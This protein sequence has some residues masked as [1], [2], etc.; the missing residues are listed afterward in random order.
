MS[1]TKCETVD[2]T[3]VPIDNN[4]S[5]LDH[6]YECEAVLGLLP[7]FSCADAIEVPA[8]KNGMPVTFET[9]GIVRDA[10]GLTSKT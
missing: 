5:A 8:T 2:I 7:K 3:Y 9:N 4:R 6:A 10:R 1:L